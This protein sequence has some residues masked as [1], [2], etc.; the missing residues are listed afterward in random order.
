MKITLCSSAMFFEKLYKIKEELEKIGHVVFLPSMVNYHNLKETSLAKIQN[1]LIKDHF[2]KINNS[3]AL[4]VANFEKKGIK[5]YIGGNVFLEM[6]KAF[7]KGIPIFLLNKIPNISYKE[8][9]IAM[10]PIII[11][12]KLKLLIKKKEI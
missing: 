8:E 10:Q 11:G 9:I 3:D 7:D 6:G 2:M 5:G 4:Y 12:E 1:E